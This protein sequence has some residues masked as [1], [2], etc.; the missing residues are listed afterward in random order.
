[1]KTVRLSAFSLLLAAS[2]VLPA[3]AGIVNLTSPDGKWNLASDEFGAYG[4]AVGGSTAQR[5]FN[6]G[7]GL[8]EYSWASSLLLVEGGTRQWLTGINLDVVGQSL[9]GPA[10]LLS[11][12]TVGST[13][14]SAFNVTG[15][16]NLRIDLVQSV[17]NAGITQ[18]FLLT[19][20]RA[21]PLTLSVLSY[22]DVDLNE[23]DSGSNVIALDTGTMRVTGGG[24]TLYFSPASPGYVGYLAGLIAGGG[25]T[26]TLDAVAYNNFGIPAGAVNQFRDVAGGAVGANLDANNDKVSDIAADVGYIFQNNVTIPAGGSVSFSYGTQAVPEPSS[27]LL[28]LTSLGLAARRRRSDA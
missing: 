17:T 16:A 22:H 13:R 20:N 5:D 21:T 14:T 9:L 23:A 26:S 11:D 28:A 19:N 15:F 24:R 18:Q 1:M 25:I 10:N 8:T 7:A 2:S 12:V 6:N 27:A 4:I 3:T